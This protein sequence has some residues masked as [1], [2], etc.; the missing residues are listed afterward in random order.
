MDNAA[1]TDGPV[2]RAPVS[3]RRATTFS[4]PLGGHSSLYG[5]FLAVIM[6]SAEWPR[7]RP[8][9]SSDRTPSQG[10]RFHRASL[11]VGRAN[12]LD[13]VTPPHLSGGNPGRCPPGVLSGE[14]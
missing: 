8:P 9:T 5:L 3:D 6:S 10:R 4:R 1:S 14:F 13:Q 7:P 2:R 11:Y 12:H